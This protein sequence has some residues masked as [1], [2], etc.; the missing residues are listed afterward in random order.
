MFGSEDSAFIYIQSWTKKRKRN[1]CR[2][3]IDEE[4]IKG[5]DNE[6]TRSY[7][8]SSRQRFF[9]RKSLTVIYI[10]VLGEQR[11][12]LK[13]AMN[14]DSDTDGEEMMRVEEFYELQTSVDQISNGAPTYLGSCEMLGLNF[15]H[16]LVKDG[17]PY[18]SKRKLSYRD[19][20]PEGVL[21]LHP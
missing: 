11:G 7:Q 6:R 20:P 4:R 19:D 2:R 10:S 5:L 18:S 12:T 16:S 8:K 14:L 3:P 17:R 21:G 13:A 15:T 1:A 9:Y